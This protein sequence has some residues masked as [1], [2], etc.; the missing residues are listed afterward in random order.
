MF[1][2]SEYNQYKSFS[3]N[4]NLPPL[5][6]TNTA[7]ENGYVQLFTDT[8]GM[9]AL[10]TITVSSNN[11]VRW[12]IFFIIL[13]ILLLIF[14]IFLIERLVTKRKRKKMVDELNENVKAKA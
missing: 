5:D 2:L 10:C 12:L 6:I 8:T 4:G 1:K 11:G 3:I 13:L 14:I 9:I 7:D